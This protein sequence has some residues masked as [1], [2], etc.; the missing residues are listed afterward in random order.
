MTVNG[1]KITVVL[2]FTG[3]RLCSSVKFNANLI[4]IRKTE[5]GAAVVNDDSLRL[6]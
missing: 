3:S 6:L 1:T 4:R 5:K 2:E